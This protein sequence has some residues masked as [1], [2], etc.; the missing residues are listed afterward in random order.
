[1]RPFIIVLG[2]LLLAAHEA[3]ADEVRLRNGSIIQGR[4]VREDKD[5]VVVDLGRGRMNILK[6]DVMSIRRG[7]PEPAES[8]PTSR[9]PAQRRESPPPRERSTRQGSEDP[10]D[11]VPAKGGG[12]PRA[13]TVQAPRKKRDRAAGPTPGPKVVPV[14]RTSPPAARG[15][16]PEPPR[17]AAPRAGESGTAQ[18]TSKPKSGR[19]SATP[20]W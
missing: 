10:Q 5:V 9:D 15:T 13:Q 12:I 2:V 17:N 3:R 4:I 16:A 1:M 11:A 18:A 20:D 19:G 8:A 14:E 7:A 6:R